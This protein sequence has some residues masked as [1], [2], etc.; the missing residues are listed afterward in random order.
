MKAKGKNKGAALVMTVLIVLSV[1]VGAYR[2]FS[3]M[4]DQ[5]QTVFT[6]GAEGDGLGIANDL[7]ERVKLAYNLVTIARK[8]LSANDAAIADVLKARDALVNAKDISDKYRANVKLTEATTT[9]YFALGQKQLSETDARYRVNLFNDLSSRNDTISHD[10][11]NQKA[12]AY[13]Q[14]LSAFPASILRLIT[15]ARTAPLFE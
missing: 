13:N 9:L 1:W 3:R 10:P 7:N 8:Y 12:L 4:Y 2:S 6:A 11:Y 14:A 5:V 15:F